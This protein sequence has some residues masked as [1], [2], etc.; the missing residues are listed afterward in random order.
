MN[1]F[2]SL[3]KEY[4]TIFPDLTDEQITQRALFMSKKYATIKKGPNVVHLDYFDGLL[5]DSDIIDIETT[6][7]KAGLELSRFDK[8]G[9]PYASLEDFT[10]QVALYI[11]DPIISNIL[12]GISANIVWDSIKT[13][14]FLVWRKI[15]ERYWSKK[16]T[17]ERKLRPLNFGLH[18]N[19]DKNTSLDLKIDG[20]LTEEA[21]LKALDKVID[22]I[23]QIKPNES[24]APSKFFQTN[25][26]GNWSEI[27]VYNKIQKE[28]LQQKKII[29][30]KK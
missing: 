6:L 27:D 29:K 26:D 17:D 4:K 30:K 19:I 12:L 5:I 21:A 2:E 3:K 11:S 13:S 20:G 16:K 7:I 9:V 24:P 8:S 1:D 14:S 22:L 28:M 15:K 23:K 18:I 25:N 10:L